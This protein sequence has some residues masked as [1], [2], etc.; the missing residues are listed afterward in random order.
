MKAL[1]QRIAQRLLEAAV[2]VWKTEPAVVIG[3]VDALLILLA[4]AGLPIPAEFK[5]LIDIFLAAAAVPAIRSQVTPNRL[6][7][8][9]P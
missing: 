1:I 7:P 6:A 5:T 4:N 3:C 8:P 9:T 2:N